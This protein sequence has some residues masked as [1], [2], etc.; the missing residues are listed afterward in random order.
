[1]KYFATLLLTIFISQIATGQDDYEKFIQALVKG[2]T[3]LAAQ[4]ERNYTYENK[5]EPIQRIPIPLLKISLG[6]LFL[7]SN[8]NVLKDSLLSLFKIENIPEENQHLRKIFYFYSD[9]IRI[10]V[11]F[12][13]EVSKGAIFSKEYFLQP[14]TSNDIYLTGML[15]P[16]V[17]KYY[18][19]DSQPIQ[20]TADFVFKLTKI[21]ENS[22]VVKVVAINPEIVSGMGLGVH[23]PMNIYTKAQPTTIEE[24]SFLLF[25]AD[26]LGDATLLP[27]KLPNN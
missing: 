5:I 12:D 2:D 26:K 14:N 25:I 3:V 4:I 6:I 8:M 9:T 23:G 10:P 15:A 11:F 22:T 18:Y 17:S 16:W 20:Y 13:A 7:N 27:L 19:S 24:Y 1:M 21:D